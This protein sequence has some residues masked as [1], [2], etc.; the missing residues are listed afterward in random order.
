MWE[1]TYQDVHT[2]FSLLS[3]YKAPGRVIRPRALQF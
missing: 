3:G 1:H 2:E